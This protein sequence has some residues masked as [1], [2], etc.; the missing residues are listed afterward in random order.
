MRVF[1][2]HARE[3]NESS[4]NEELQCKASRCTTLRLL[5]AN[6]HSADFDASSF[7]KRTGHYCPQQHFMTVLIPLISL[8]MLHHTNVER[9]SNYKVIFVYLVHH[10]ANNV[11]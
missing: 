5:S 4:S 9:S 10:N 1:I 6:R 2:M 3:R 11:V 7:A 8:S